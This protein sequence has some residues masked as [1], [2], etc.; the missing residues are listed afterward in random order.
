VTRCRRSLILSSAVMASAFAL[1]AA[2][3]GGGSRGVA[4]VSSSTTT[5]ATTPQSALVEY[6]RCMRSHGVPSFPD[7]RRVGGR[8]F[9]LTIQGLV[10]SSAQFE[11]AQRACDHLLPRGGGTEPQ[12]T[13]QQSR[14]RVAAELSFARCMRSHGES[15]FPDPNGQGELSLAMVQAQGID[16]H[17]SVFLREVQ[18]CL[19]AAHGWLTPAMVR[20]AL[21]MPAG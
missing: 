12:E 1:L 13:A 9:K 14:A 20:K 17:S 4:Q 3:C 16:V 6:S 10:A 7:P 21:S 18:A 15:R 11:T 2:G 19:P 8:T 5:P